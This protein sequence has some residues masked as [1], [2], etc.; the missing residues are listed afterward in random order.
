MPTARDSTVGCNRAPGMQLIG[1]S[2]GR[3][4]SSASTGSPS[5][6][7][8]PADQTSSSSRR[9]PPAT[10]GSPVA[11]FHATFLV[12]LHAV[13]DR[14][15]LAPEGS[16]GSCR[17]PVATA[18]TG[19]GA[20]ASPT[21]CWTTAMESEARRR[22]GAASPSSSGTSRGAPA[23]SRR[24]RWARGLHLRHEDY[25]LA[26]RG[27][28]PRAAARRAMTRGAP[29]TGEALALRAAQPRYGGRSTP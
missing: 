16:T 14:P 21:T 3:S 19:P 26:D 5:L 9:E 18:T 27:A 29:S 20:I 25:L 6:W 12:F 28:S 7:A 17:S 11:P 1:V 8:S 13:E 10:S 23:R 2:A 22:S 4:G 15:V 24:P